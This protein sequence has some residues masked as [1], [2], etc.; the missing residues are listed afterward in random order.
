AFPSIRNEVEQAEIVHAYGAF[1]T[2]GTTYPEIAKELLAWMAS[3]ESQ[4]DNARAISRTG[5]NMQVD[6][7]LYSD[8]QQ[9][10]VEYLHDVKEF[11]PLLE[12]SM[13]PELARTALEVFQEYWKNPEHIDAALEQLEKARRKVVG[14]N[15]AGN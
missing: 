15:S 5:A 14:L 3:A 6:S 2:S 10:L 11:V 4:S 13:E 1:M 12:L 8:V 7:S 9:R